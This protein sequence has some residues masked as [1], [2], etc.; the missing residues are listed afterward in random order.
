MAKIQTL[1][2]VIK[3]LQNSRLRARKS[4]RKKRG[5]V[6]DQHFIAVYCISHFFSSSNIQ[7]NICRKIRY[8]Y[9]SKWNIICTS[10]FSRC[11]LR[12]QAR[13][14]LILTF[15]P[16][17]SSKLQ[18]C[19]CNSYFAYKNEILWK[20]YKTLAHLVFSLN[21]LVYALSYKTWF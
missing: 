11:L 3:L 17:I 8:I 13:V 10:Q 20:L 21:V 16:R 5:L 19:L 15:W 12:K 6:E 4:D 18:S 1:S 9:V 2:Y 14:N 7:A